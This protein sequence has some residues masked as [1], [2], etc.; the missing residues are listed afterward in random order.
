MTWLIIGAKGQL[1]SDLMN[2]LG[3]RAV[4]LDVPD[5]D[6][7]DLA[8]VV[9][10]MRATS[11]TVVINCAAYT[12]VDAAESDEDTAEAINGTG[13]AHVA[14]AATGSRLIHVSTDYVFDGAAANPY[15]EDAQPDPRSA[16]GRT[17]LHGEQAALDHPQS[18]VVRTAWLY[19]VA[20]SNFVKTMLTLEKTRETL[21]VVDDQVGQP[22]WSRD[23][24]AQLIL[25]GESGAEPGIYHGT[26]SGQTS[27]YGFTRK[28]F[29][30]IG[31]DPDRVQPT[32]TAAFP[33]PAKR[34]TY[35]VLG[36][37]RWRHQG[38]PSMRH[39]EDALTA[40]LPDIAAAVSRPAP[41]GKGPDESNQ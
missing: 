10:A 29:E 4:G 41:A 3:E 38:L 31:A 20:G 1:G 34:P 39:W 33:R 5:I 7:T 27:W 11:P 6:I 25:L 12:A 35:S 28:I 15:A 30:L 9:D 2:L 22:T 37:D 18:Y 23:L 14:E 16:Y 26:N 21:S 36:H 17:K 24:A 19:G 32:T 13:A 40:A 8:T